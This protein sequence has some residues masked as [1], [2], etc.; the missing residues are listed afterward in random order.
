MLAAIFGN[1]DLPIILSQQLIQDK[2]PFIAICF[3][4]DNYR[5]IHSLKSGNLVFHLSSIDIKQIIF[6]IAKHNVS[7]AVICGGVRFKGLESIKVPFSKILYLIYAF[8]SYNKGDNFLLNVAAKMLKAQGVNLIGVHEIIPQILTKQIDNIN[9]S[10]ASSY[11][12]NIKLG[13]NILNYNSLFDIGQSVVVQDGR[14]LGVEAVEGTDALITRCGMLKNDLKQKPILIK[15]PKIG[16][17]MK[18]D[19]P[20]IG[21]QTIQNLV[22]GGYAGLVVKNESLIFLDKERC[23]EL[24]KQNEMFLKVLD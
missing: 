20:T 3:D 19:M 4:T 7:Q 5:K 18:L 23:K 22:N 15:M 6:Y 16:Q 14:V 1:G 2:T 13:V 21:L 17:N 12:K 10:L 11:H 9:L 8:F 24:L